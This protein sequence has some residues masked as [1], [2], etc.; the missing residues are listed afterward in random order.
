MRGR[1]RYL[2]AFEL[3]RQHLDV[4]KVRRQALRLAR[5]NIAIGAH[6][7]AKLVLERRV[8]PPQRIAILLWMHNLNIPLSATAP[9]SHIIAHC[10]ATH[11]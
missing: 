6:Q 4:V 8:Q 2:G 9:H 1:A 5:R 3:Q 7:T 10:R 11:L